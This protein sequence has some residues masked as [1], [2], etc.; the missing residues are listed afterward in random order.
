M[1]PSS[2]RRTFAAVTTLALLAAPAANAQVLYNNGPLVTNP[3]AGVGGADVSALAPPLTTFGFSAPSSG[4]RLADNFSIVGPAWN[5]SG[6]RF[7]A[8]QTGSSTTS[9]FTGAFWRLWNG[10]PGDGGASVVAGDIATNTISSTAF[11][12]VYRA[13][14]TALTNSQRPIMSIDASTGG[15][16]LGAGNYWLEWSL[17]G[18]LAA[19]P[20]VPPVTIAGQ[21]VTGN[22]RQ[23]TVS[24][25]LWADANVADATNGQVFYQ[26][27][28]PFEVLGTTNVVPEPSTYALMATGLAGLI[29]VARRRR[30]QS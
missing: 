2:L 8:Y 10:R 5:V 6:F 22:G 28:L 29:G 1:S 25:G 11:T 26:Q 19:G 16:T 15:L 18:S 21:N 17:S 23:F 9:T 24:S 3:G 4:F 7:F 20:F 14:S 13:Q 30:A 12:G 27:D